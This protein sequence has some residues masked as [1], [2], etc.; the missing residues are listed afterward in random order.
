MNSIGFRDRELKP[1][2]L[3]HN[4]CKECGCSIHPDLV[5]RHKCHS[6]K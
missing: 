4:Y 3:Y 1:N 2:E 6:A 5:H